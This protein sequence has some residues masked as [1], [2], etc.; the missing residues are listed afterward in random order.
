[1]CIVCAHGYLGSRV[2][3]T[4]EQESQW[5]TTQ[6]TVLSLKQNIATISMQ[7]ASLRQ[8]LSLKEETISDMIAKQASIQESLDENMKELEKKGERCAEM[9]SHCMRTSELTAMTLV[10][11]DFNPNTRSAF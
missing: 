6:H 1:M 11:M 2:T 9:L 8:E 5:Q 3:R 10:Y 7:E 4:A